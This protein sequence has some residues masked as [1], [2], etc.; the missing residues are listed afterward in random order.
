MFLDNQ[1]L[2][3]SLGHDLMGVQFVSLQ[4]SI[5]FRTDRIIILWLR[6]LPL[7][8]MN[9]G[10]ST[11][12]LYFPN[13][14]LYL[15]YTPILISKKTTSIYIDFPRDYLHLFWCP[16]WLPIHPWISPVTTLTYL[17]LPWFHPS[18]LISPL[19]T[20]TYFVSMVTTYRYDNLISTIT[21][22]IYLDFPSH[23]Q[24]TPWFPQ[25]LLTSTL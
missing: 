23:F 25:W 7:T 8:L 14:N 10:N 22:Y 6:W 20:F 12:Y 15:P 16:K 24:Y 19:T 3:G 2:A 17:H 5:N 21:T 18:H 1:S 4:M 13:N 11:V 9:K